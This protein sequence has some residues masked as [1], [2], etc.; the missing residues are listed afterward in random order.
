MAIAL[1]GDREGRDAL[2]ALLDHFEYLGK[3]VEHVTRTSKYAVTARREACKLTNAIGLTAIDVKTR[4]YGFGPFK[5]TCITEVSSGRRYKV[6]ESISK[7]SETLE[8]NSAWI[9]EATVKKIGR[10][11]MHTL[12][13]YTM[14]H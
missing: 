13:S 2:F 5:S 11:L 10:E 8:K 1:N 12:V 14:A 9:L 6:W 4:T 3:Q 7:M